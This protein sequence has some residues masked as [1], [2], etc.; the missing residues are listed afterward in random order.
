MITVTQTITYDLTGHD[1]HTVLH[2][3]VADPDAVPE[4]EPER[5]MTIPVRAYERV[6][7]RLMPPMPPLQVRFPLPLP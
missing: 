2:T 3:H 1:V 6:Q 5:V 7:L 4:H